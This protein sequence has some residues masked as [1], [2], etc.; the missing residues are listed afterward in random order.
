VRVS[1]HSDCV[2]A[3]AVHLVDR[4]AV[5]HAAGCVYVCVIVCKTRV[6]IVVMRVRYKPSQV[7]L[8]IVGPTLATLVRACA[9]VRTRACLTITAQGHVVCRDADD[10]VQLRRAAKQGT[11]VQLA[12]ERECV[13]CVGVRVA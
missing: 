13:R 4:R 5:H 7:L 8:D 11:D 12:A 3:C 10:R 9:C 1:G 6:V 2:H